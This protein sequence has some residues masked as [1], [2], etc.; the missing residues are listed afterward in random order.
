MRRSVGSAAPETWKE[1]SKACGNLRL[2]T[3]YYVYDAVPVHIGPYSIMEHD[4]YFLC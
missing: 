2:A 1:S 3:G 4:R